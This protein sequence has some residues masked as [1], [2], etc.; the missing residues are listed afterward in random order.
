MVQPKQRYD[1][2][3]EMAPYQGIQVSEYGGMEVHEYPGPASDGG[4]EK[5]AFHDNVNIYDEDP[6]SRLRRD[7]KTRQIAMIALG[8]ALG[9]GLLIQT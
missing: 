8:G 7:L 3:L 6:N 4:S 1:E 9:T 5:H 2:G